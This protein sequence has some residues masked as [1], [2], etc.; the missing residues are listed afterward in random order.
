MYTG[1]G[2]YLFGTCTASS[3]RHQQESRAYQLRAIGNMTDNAMT[4]L[5]GWRTNA[6][7]EF[8]VIF[9]EMGDVAE[10]LEVTVESPTVG[11]MPAVA[12][13]NQRSCR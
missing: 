10:N 2:L 12:V 9:S 8:H 4:I 13:S 5:E 11:Y 7:E 6:D 3:D 1:P